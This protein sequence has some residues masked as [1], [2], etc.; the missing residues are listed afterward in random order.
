MGPRDEQPL[1]LLL[2]RVAAALRSEVTAGVLE[3]L[4]LSF[5]QYIC[6]RILSHSPGRSNAELARDVNVSPQAMNMVV[7]GLQQRGLVTRPATVSAG[8]S[9]PA[10]LTREGTALLND[11]D[12]GVRD[13]ER[14]VL[15]PLGDQDRREF[16]RM[17]AQ[18]G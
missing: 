17:L 13:A 7:R 18:L 5:P 10:E 3:P 9:L 15:A 2:V 4:G 8:R 14:K 12:P 6:M 11:I 16:R 1:G